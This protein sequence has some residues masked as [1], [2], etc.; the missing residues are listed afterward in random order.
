MGGE[1]KRSERLQLEQRV[2]TNKMKINREKYKVIYLEKKL[3]YRMRKIRLKGSASEN[4]LGILV[5]HKLTIFQYCKVA[6]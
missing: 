6:V 3:M 5:N 2:K 4:D 1:G